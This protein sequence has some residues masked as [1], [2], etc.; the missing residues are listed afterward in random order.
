MQNEG[1]DEIST[2]DNTEFIGESA[3]EMFIRGKEGYPNDLLDKT[4]TIVKIKHT[5]ANM[6]Q[7]IALDL[8]LWKHMIFKGIKK[9]FNF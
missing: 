5:E 4:K 3:Q 2:F 6:F 7:K 1:F 9:Y 8:G